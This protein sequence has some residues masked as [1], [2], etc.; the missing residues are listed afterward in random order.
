MT[1]DE[2]YLALSQLVKSNSKELESR[3]D[4]MENRLSNRIDNLDAEMHCIEKRLSDRIDN[5]DAEMHCIEKRLSDRIDNMDAEMHCIEKRLSDRIDN[6]DVEM[7]CIE[8]RLDS[9]IKNIKL[10]LEN[11]MEPRLQNI[12]GCY[13]STFERYKV[14][15]EKYEGLEMD[16]EVIKSVV[17]KHNQILC[18]ITA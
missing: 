1:N 16:I 14:Y 8:N 5:M 11:V 6:M 7:H 18:P 2:L 10:F 4:A 17:S 3:M 12:E 13:T 9:G 15:A